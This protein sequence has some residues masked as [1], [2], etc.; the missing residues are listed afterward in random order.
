MNRN[1]RWKKSQGEGSSQAKCTCGS[2]CR[3]LFKLPLVVASG[4]GRMWD[5]PCGEAKQKSLMRQPR[6]C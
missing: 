6:G 4:V 1:F 5:R 3:E 2:V